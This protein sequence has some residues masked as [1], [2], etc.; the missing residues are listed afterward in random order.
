MLS[1]VRTGTW[2]SE[3]TAS[4]WTRQTLWPSWLLTSPPSPTSDSWE[5]RALPGAWPPAPPS[6]GTTHTITPPHTLSRSKGFF[7]LPCHTTSTSLHKLLQ[8]PNLWRG[9]T[10]SDEDSPTM[11]KTVRSHTHNPHTHIYS[12][13]INIVRYVRLE[14]SRG[15]WVR[16]CDH[17]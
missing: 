2:S 9:A 16:G 4:L 7:A 8:Q 14:P 3:K 17:S 13:P 15:C 6:T 5:S 1:V 10:L 12:P 11:N